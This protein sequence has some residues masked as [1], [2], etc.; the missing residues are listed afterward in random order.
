MDIAEVLQIA[1]NL[2]FAETGKHLDDLQETV[3]KGVW[4][5]KSYDK[6]AE[7]S[8]CSESYIRNI[9]YKLW[10]IFSHHL[11]Q[12]IHKSNFRS[13]LSRLKL[14]SSPIVIQQNKN[15][16]F[17]FCP[18]YPQVN[19]NKQS[20]HDQPSCKYD[21]QS[22]PQ[23]MCFYGREEE[24][25]TLYNWIFN[26][27]TRLVSVLGLG[28]IGK[29][30][31]VKR[32]IDFNLEKFEVIIWKSL[33]FPKSLDLF[34]DDCLNI[35]E[36]ESPK[37]TDQKLK[38]FLYVLNDKKCLIVIDDV[39][40]IFA[41]GK[42]AGIYLD[43]YKNY[44]NLFTMIAE[45]KHQSS[46]ILISREK[47][48]EMEYLDAELSPMKHLELS[49]LKN[50][51][52]FKNQS[53]HDE[54]NW[55]KLINLSEGNPLYLKDIAVLIKDVFAGYVTEFLGENNLVIT[56]NMQISFHQIFNRLSPIEQQ[57]VLELSKSHQPVSREDVREGLNLS[58]NLSSMELINGLQSLKQ[59][60]LLKTI[61]QEK[62]L[63]QLSPVFREY[64]RM[65]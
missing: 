61:V 13:T 5:G 31:L 28:G 65:I 36:K 35:L 16:S 3:I 49:G 38:R 29:T 34:I 50:M 7:N 10:R 40:N 41:S 14:T 2:V 33:K 51:E 15:I 23:I 26:Q 6:I 45:I 63:F 44:Q 8:H 18:S 56:K 20:N 30:T 37:S 4:E 48:P 59:R 19:E 47:C 57:I 21:L 12:D 58:S 42:Y 60:Y 39:E 46:F 64:L 52:V 22:S 43:E 62:V 11:D 32:F 54:D 1:D 25:E 9:G 24:L 27:N 17:N 55:F 53:L